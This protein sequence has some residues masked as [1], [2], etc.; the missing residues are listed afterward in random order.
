MS[1]ASADAA[2]LS[3]A[4]AYASLKMEQ[5]S[6]S[7]SY[8]LSPGSPISITSPKQ[9]APIHY[10]RSRLLALANSPL[11]VRPEA[12]KPLI[13]WFGEFDPPPSKPNQ[14]TPSHNQSL[15]STFPRPHSLQS[16]EDGNHSSITSPLNVSFLPMMGRGQPP[17]RNPFA[18]FGKF[19]S[20]DNANS[21]SLGLNL[22]QPTN[23]SNNGPKLN[24]RGIDRDSAPHLGRPDNSNDDNPRRR[25]VDSYPG[26]N[27]N[28]KDRVVN[29]LL[30]EDGNTSESR[31]SARRT[32]DRYAT[33]SKRDG[34]RDKDRNNRTSPVN[35]RDEADEHQQPHW[36]R[37]L[38]NGSHANHKKLQSDH[39]HGTS[40][41]ER[42]HRENIRD[43]NENNHTY[44]KER[45]KHL[46]PSPTPGRSVSY[47]SS[48]PRDKDKHDDYNLNEWPASAHEENAMNDNFVSSMPLQGKRVKDG[49]W[50]SG[51]GKWE[52]SRQTNDRNPSAG[53]GATSETDAIQAWKA[54][55]KAMDAKK[56][57]AAAAAANPPQASS[58]LSPD[59]KKANGSDHRQPSR[60]FPDALN[61]K[62]AD[63]D[64]E[65]NAVD[66]QISLIASSAKT[67]HFASLLQNNNAT[68]GPAASAPADDDVASQ[69][70]ASRFAKFFDNSTHQRDE[71]EHGPGFGNPPPSAPSHFDLTLS[72]H[73]PLHLQ[74]SDHSASR[75][76]L[77]NEDQ[78][79]ILHRSA[80]ADPENMARVLSMLQMSSQQPLEPATHPSLQD[81]Q[82][83]PYQPMKNVAAAG[84]ATSSQPQHHMMDLNAYT[85]QHLPS[86]K[87]NSPPPITSPTGFSSGLQN[88]YNKQQVPE[89]EFNR[90]PISVGHN[91]SIGI[92][93]NNNYISQRPSQLPS[94]VN[95]MRSLEEILSHDHQLQHHQLQP[96]GPP[97]PASFTNHLPGQASMNALVQQMNLNKNKIGSSGMEPPLQMYPFQPTMN[98]PQPTT[99]NGDRNN[100]E[101][102]KLAFLARQLQQ[103]RLSPNHSINPLSPT[104][105]HLINQQ[106]GVQPRMDLRTINSNF[107]SQLA[108]YPG[109]P[110]PHLEHQRRYSGALPPLP[111]P[112]PPLPPHH[113]F[114]HPPPPPPSAMFG[115]GAHHIL[116]PAPIPPSFQNP[117][118]NNRNG[119]NL[120]RSQFVGV[121]STVP[122][123]QSF[124]GNFGNSG[125]GGVGG[126][127]G[128]QMDLMSLLNAGQNRRMGNGG[129][130]V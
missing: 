83:Y 50:D 120:N 63:S 8:T 88:V 73:N 70:R 89:A 36:R 111:P 77:P 29:R 90:R 12:L 24:R 47:N 28:S 17:A 125:V 5:Q 1:V 21:G 119:L 49:L 121:Q 97:P 11:C 129:N 94:P 72:Q 45:D 128:S 51:E 23:P 13:D 91:H 108:Q 80:S 109:P 66:S 64:H 22:H 113:L 14:S 114:N 74:Q 96:F 115:Q 31:S 127:G 55:M 71:N 3:A 27:N 18:N 10:T 85:S 37:P 95:Q 79:S 75:S 57:Q 43:F 7:S 25:L 39:H 46:G 34:E 107:N 122:P 16:P 60:N 35:N 112:P 86:S 117:T 105:P 87:F 38:P 68:A 44:G 106:G 56:K 26:N 84:S 99:V 76:S 103:Q 52:M 20:E 67:P 93:A 6:S 100:L 33:D 126:G 101:N 65:E 40:T 81:G 15:P 62:L 54:E 59:S 32:M 124:V 69:P 102:Q 58:D 4:R 42:D 2:L 98:L 41:K 118:S 82:S 48:R 9:K 61:L 110:P 92:N 19:G 104:T 123:P 53:L 130:G 30:P 116:P 78:R